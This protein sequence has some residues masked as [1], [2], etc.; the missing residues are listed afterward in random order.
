VLLC[1]TPEFIAWRPDFSSSEQA[2]PN[3][4]KLVCEGVQLSNALGWVDWFDEPAVQVELCEACGHARCESGGYVHVS[5]LGKHVLWTQ[6]HIDP[7]DPFESYQY[8][9]SEP[10]RKYGA[11][12]IPAEEWE[13]WRHR[14]AE[15]PSSGM[16]PRT[17]RRDLFDAWLREA[18]VFGVW[19]ARDQ[20]AELA[21]ER[22]VAA[23]PGETANALRSIDA[24]VH[25]FREE[26][27]APV[28]GELVAVASHGASVETLY[29]DV[30]DTFDRPVL[31]EW[32][33]V[34]RRGGHVAPVF[35]RELMLVPEPARRN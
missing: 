1:A 17:E 12:A 10:V 13:A 18:P 29:V 19:D 21:R 8:R 14:F 7:S 32:P 20:I 22:A 31:H 15:L 24:I 11:I 2:D 4:T 34:A 30:P 35:G 6:P 25:W 33:A 3:W 28:D 27:D 26:P 16:F 23:E 9:A 5:R